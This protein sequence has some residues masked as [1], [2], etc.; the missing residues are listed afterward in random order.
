MVEREGEAS[1]EWLG[2]PRVE[3]CKENAQVCNRTAK[4]RKK[5]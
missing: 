2:L 4:E 1:E 5:E 3:V